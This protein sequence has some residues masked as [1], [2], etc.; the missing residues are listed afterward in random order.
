MD[1]DTILPGASVA[2]A[3][4]LHEHRPDRHRQ[5]GREDGIAIEDQ[6]ARCRFE[7]EGL[8]KLLRDPGG[9]R[10]RRDGAADHVA[11]ALADDEKHVKAADNAVARVKKSIAAMPSR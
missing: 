3:R 4:W 1:G 2:G 8:A 5:P 6:E 10:D 9:R 7:G 11:P